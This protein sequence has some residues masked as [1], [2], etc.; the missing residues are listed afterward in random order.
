MNILRLKIIDLQDWWMWVD[1]PVNGFIYE[2]V[3][4]NAHSTHLPPM[5]QRGIWCTRNKL[6]APIDYIMGEKEK[7]AV[8]CSKYVTELDRRIYTV[9]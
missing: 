4:N 7:V 8:N 6:A 1:R 9:Q 3:I 2:N 5:P